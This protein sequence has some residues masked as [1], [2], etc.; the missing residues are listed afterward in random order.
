MAFGSFSQSQTRADHAMQICT[1]VKQN[2]KVNVHIGFTG[3]CQTPEM[4]P[5]SLT[6]P[7]DEHTCSVYSGMQ[8]SKIKE[9]QDAHKTSRNLRGAALS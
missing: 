9:T 4:T 7:R 6:L 3:H 5:V 8:F 2:C 1:Q